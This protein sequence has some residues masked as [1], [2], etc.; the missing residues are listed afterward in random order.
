[1]RL[2]GSQRHEV[3][4]DS[5]SGRRLAVPRHLVDATY[6][7]FA[8]H[9]DR[10]EESV[11]YWY[12]AESLRTGR[13]GKVDL[14]AA[15]G[16]PCGRYT[17]GQFAVRADDAARLGRA[18]MSQSLVCLAQFHTHPG[19]GTEH[20]SHDDENAIS[21]RDGFL[22]LVAP[23]YGGAGRSLQDGV[24]VHEAWKRQWYVLDGG[25]L[26]ERILVVNDIVDQRQPLG[27]GRGQIGA[28]RGGAPPAPR[29]A[30][31]EDKAG[32]AFVPR[33][34]WRP[35]R[36]ASILLCKIKRALGRT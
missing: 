5:K 31:G 7:I 19:Y 18:M 4:Q 34:V 25:A 13:G 11:V 6:D 35:L 9:G 17:E 20:S 36:A 12:G 10:N 30:G 23:C 2:H 27:R 33:A 21:M 8:E 1:M 29:R 28:G 14:V 26:E 24:T 16:I 22:S 32:A 15:V 3:V